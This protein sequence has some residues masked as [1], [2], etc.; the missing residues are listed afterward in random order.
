MEETS[1]TLT[2]RSTDEMLDLLLEASPAITSF[3]E[4]IKADGDLTTIIQSAK[5]RMSNQE[6]GLKVLPL[7]LKKQ[8]RQDIYSIVA[9]FTKKT[10]E[11]I[12]S[13][14]LK[15]TINDIKSL[16]TEDFINFT[17]SIT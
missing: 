17:Q 9:A 8:Y 6:F 12:A 1:K 7:L 15:E 13:Q 11:Q 5:Q 14:N 10:P 16:L 4:K 3:I 2:Q